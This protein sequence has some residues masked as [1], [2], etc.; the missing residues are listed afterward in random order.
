[1]PALAPKADWINGDKFDTQGCRA[2]SNDGVTMLTAEGAGE[3][4]CGHTG[5]YD[6]P[7][8]RQPVAGDT[9]ATVWLFTIN[10]QRYPDITV[11]A[12]QSELW[13]VANLSATVTY[14]IDLVDANGTRQ[15]LH[16]VTLDGVV[17][18]SPDPRKAGHSKIGVKLQQ[19]LL[20]PASRAEILIQN[21][22]AGGADR[23]LTLRTEGIETA[24]TDQK[25]KSAADYVG[26]PWPAVKLAQVTLKGASQA[27]PLESL[28]DVALPDRSA[29]LGGAAELRL[30]RRAANPAVPPNCVV[31]PD[32][33]Y[34]RR[35]TFAQ[36]DADFR[37][38]SDVVNADGQSIDDPA[39]NDRPHTIDPQIFSHALPPEAVRHIC[40]RFGETEVWELVNSTPELHNF[41]IHQSKFRLADSHD[42]GAPPGLT[43]ETAWRDP[44]RVVIGQIADL[45]TVRPVNKVDVWHDTIPIPPRDKL[46][47]P[48]VVFVAIPFRAREQIGTYVFHCHILEHEDG[49][50]MATVQVFDP[51]QWSSVIPP[52]RA[53]QSANTEFCGAPP[54]ELTDAN[55]KPTAMSL[56]TSILTRLAAVGQ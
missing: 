24:G 53:A 36:T 20:M 50:M 48:G 4:F 47:N 29:E 8:S 28:L 51:L 56:F 7:R 6:D 45:Q 42:P 10:G 33:N 19:L 13:R 12:G 16:L 32:R 46:G 38:G 54:A 17:A 22:A 1:M 34:R 40:P 9:R 37:L 25:D 49:G 44:G 21:T 2:K 5:I 52:V 26:D 41:H 31:L 35:I 14:V 23:S 18:G 39:S 3:G 11:S 27:G 30:A 43:V 55:R 15:D